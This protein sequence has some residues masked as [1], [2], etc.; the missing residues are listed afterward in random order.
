[1]LATQSPGDLDYKA[2]DSIGT[3]WIGRIGSTT[4]STR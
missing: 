3:W 4:A 1:M 2:R